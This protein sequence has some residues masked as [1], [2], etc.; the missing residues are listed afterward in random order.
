MAQPPMKWLKFKVSADEYQDARKV[1]IESKERWIG[2]FFRKVFSS[3]IKNQ[4]PPKK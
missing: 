4:L 3:A 1:F 2:R